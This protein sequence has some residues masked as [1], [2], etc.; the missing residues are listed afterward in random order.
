MEEHVGFNL[1]GVPH[2]CGGRI[3]DDATSDPTDN[4][5]TDE[6]YSYDRAADA[7]TKRMDLDIERA[8]AAAVVFEDG[9]VRKKGIKYALSSFFYE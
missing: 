1:N 4:T 6:C 8:R 5:V 9:R 2:V 7:W 3:P